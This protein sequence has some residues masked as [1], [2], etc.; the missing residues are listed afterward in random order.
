MKYAEVA[1][2]EEGKEEMEEKEVELDGGR[3]KDAVEA[4]GD[5]GGD[6]G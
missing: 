2:G 6:R 4:G 1:A 3:A 5:R